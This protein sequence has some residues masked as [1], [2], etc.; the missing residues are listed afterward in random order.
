MG[1]RV[2]KER[3]VDLLGAILFVVAIVLAVIAF[4]KP[5]QRG[6]YIVGALVLGVAGWG[7]LVMGWESWRRADR[8]QKADELRRIVRHELELQR[9][10]ENRPGDRTESD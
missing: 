2:G 6:P 9:L 8:A 3:P 4:T 1:R 7:L 5:D 10:R